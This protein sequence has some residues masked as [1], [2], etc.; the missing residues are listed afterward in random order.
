MRVLK[1][2]VKGMC[3]RCEDNCDDINQ[4]SSREH[5]RAENM[6][7]DGAMEEGIIPRSRNN[8]GKEKIYN[9]S[10]SRSPKDEDIRESNLLLDRNV[11]NYYSSHQ[12]ALL[13][14]NT[15]D[16]EREEMGQPPPKYETVVRG[17]A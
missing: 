11:T 12:A 9:D 7:A 14:P 1:R 10:F 13:T 5:Q 6:G 8:S 17:M 16:H 3:L 2:S 15:F 4:Y